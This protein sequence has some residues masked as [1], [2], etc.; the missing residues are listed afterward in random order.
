M[1]NPHG[2]GIVELGGASLQIA[3]IPPGSILA[4][5]FPV[6]VLGT[7]YP[8][9]VHSYL[10]FGQQQINGKVTDHLFASAAR[11]HVI[12]EQ[13]GDTE[14]IFNPCMLAGMYISPW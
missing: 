7:Y 13:S 8:L 6:K 3:F 2:W 12:D 5:K 4:N 14:V 10:G 9:Y 1:S 11:I